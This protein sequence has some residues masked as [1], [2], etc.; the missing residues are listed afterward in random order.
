[1]SKILE[2]KKP[3]PKKKPGLLCKRGHH[4]WTLRYA[5]KF[6]RRLGKLVSYHRCA[7]CGKEKVEDS[8]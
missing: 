6:D 4:K 1:M 3:P 5:S 7:R 2:F 8:Q